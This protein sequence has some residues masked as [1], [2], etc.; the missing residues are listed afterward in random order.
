MSQL[1]GNW[2]F[3]DGYLFQIEF[4]PDGAFSTN[5][6]RGHR[7]A[8]GK[9][10]LDGK[11]LRIIANSGRQANEYDFSPMYGMA[12]FEMET[13]GTNMTLTV[14]DHE[15]EQIALNYKATFRKGGYFL[16]SGSAGSDRHLQSSGGCLKPII[17]TV[18]IIIVILI[19][20]SR[21]L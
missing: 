21:I 14:I 12:L 6:F 17:I 11:K 7:V 5:I 16:G 2:E 4:R 3:D 8:K 15:G 10:Q 1:T 13:N 18:G 19:I 20:L 9:Y